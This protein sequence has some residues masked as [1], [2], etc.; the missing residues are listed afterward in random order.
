MA[1]PLTGLAT[2]GAVSAIL[3]VIDFS[4]KVISETK[5][6]LSSSDD[7]LRENII[8]E[9][10]TLEHSNLANRLIT[11]NNSKRPLNAEEQAVDNLAQECKREAAKL[12]E[13]LDAL[14][15][16]SG[17]RRAKRVWK[18]TRKTAKALQQRKAIERQQRYLGELHNRLSTALLQIL[19]TTQLSGFEDILDRLHDT[20]SKNAT[21]VLQSKQAILQALDAHAKQHDFSIN[22]L[23]SETFSRMD[24]L[25]AREAESD[26][27]DLIVDSLRFP[28]MR[29]RRDAIPPAYE[30]TFSWIFKESSSP[31]RTWLSSSES[32]FWVSGKAGSGKSTLMKYISNH[33]RTRQFLQFWA[34]DDK[35]VVIDS[36]LWNPGTALQRNEQGMLQELLYRVLSTNLDLVPV[37]SPRRW[38]FDLLRLR[39]PE[40]WSPYELAEALQNALEYSGNNTHFCFFIDG[41]D[42]YHGEQS[43]LITTIKSLAQD[44]RIKLCVSSRPWNIFRNAFKDMESTLRLEDLTAKDI[45]LYVERELKPLVQG[46]PLAQSLVERIVTKAKGVFFW[47]FLVIRSLREGIEEGDSMSILSQ[48]VD[49]FPADLEDYFRHILSRISKTYKRQTSQA[50]KLATLTLSEGVSPGS[51]WH[52]STSWF[53]VFW[54]LSQG[55]LDN[56]RFAFDLDIQWI[57]GDKIGAMYVE[58]RNFLSACCKDFLWLS[59]CVHP[60]AR[61]LA[62]VEFLHRTVYDFLQ[63]EDMRH[64]I[65]SDLPEHFKNPCLPSQLALA[66][67]KLIVQDLAWLCEHSTHV[68]QDVTQRVNDDEQARELLADYEKV[69]IVYLETVCPTECEFHSPRLILE[70]STQ[71]LVDCFASYQLHAFIEKMVLADSSFIQAAA[72]GSHSILAPALG[73]S[74]HHEFSISQIDLPFVHFLLTHGADT[75]GDLHRIWHPF[76]AKAVTESLSWSK[77]DQEQAA[78]VAQMLVFFDADMES[79]VV[80][81]IELKLPG[82]DG[83]W[84]AYLPLDILTAILTEQQMGAIHDP[85]KPLL[86]K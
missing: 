29:L 9:R 39:R 22:Q 51:T 26:K 12:L 65:D 14:K 15:V 73:M 82:Y 20:E 62:K 24:S 2:L 42:E 79:K 54:L 43:R 27:A 78:K 8:V 53:L 66:Q 1:E 38:S 58:T 23:L 69:A 84:N 61:G 7:A 18:T 85:V 11:H 45:G 56:P 75:N 67:L 4:A 68:M 37:A 3:Q 83:L 74:H 81:P 36:Y 30:N 49:E 13:Q 63:N 72:L 86:R 5:K 50:L 77:S 35:L 60:G 33:L 40:P 64:L 31:F 6:L 17:L 34:G 21:A 70:S 19:R 10:L 59:P 57:D 44:P 71:R 55:H 47:V 48:R 16:E 52:P 80:V 46:R 28:E 41:L 76:L 32:I 25:L